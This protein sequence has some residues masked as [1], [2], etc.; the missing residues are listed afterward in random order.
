M[1]KKNLWI[2]SVDFRLKSKLDL[3]TRIQDETFFSKNE[4]TKN[5]KYCGN[6]NKNIVVFYFRLL[7][8]W[9]LF[10]IHFRL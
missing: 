3:Y 9:V 2:L 1:L 4:E 5:R 10:L 8:I 6:I 7:F